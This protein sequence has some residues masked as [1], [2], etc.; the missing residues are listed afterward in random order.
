MKKINKNNTDKYEYQNFDFNL[1]EYTEKVKTKSSFLKKGI[2]ILPF[3][4]WGSFDGSPFISE[5]FNF[6]KWIKQNKDI[7]ENVSILEVEEKTIADL[8]S[9]QI[10]FPLVY[11]F[12]DVS[13]PIYLNVIANYLYEKLKGALLTDKYEV[14]VEALIEDKREKKTK[15]F[16]YEGSYQGFKEIVNRIDLDKMLENK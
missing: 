15:K 4:K 8:R 1:D 11:L 5:T 6:L 10:W 7:Q 9:D 13:L 14:R 2:L 16:L 3:E 12:S